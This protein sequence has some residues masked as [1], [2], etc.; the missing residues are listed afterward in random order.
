MTLRNMVAK[1]LNAVL[2]APLP[3]CV[4]HVPMGLKKRDKRDFHI[5]HYKCY[6]HKLSQ[7]STVVHKEIS[8]PSDKEMCTPFSTSSSKILQRLSFSDSENVVFRLRL[9]AAPCEQQFLSSFGKTARRYFVLVQGHD[10]Q[11]PAKLNVYSS[12]NPCRPYSAPVALQM[13][14]HQISLRDRPNLSSVPVVSVRLFVSQADVGT[15]QRPAQLSSQL[16]FLPKLQK[17]EFQRLSKLLLRQTSGVAQR[18]N[19]FPPEL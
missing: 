7:C 1:V 5:F 18:L 13:F 9:R 16:V 14:H 4:Q 2:S 8:P 12:A 3:I 17:H 15:S 6:S 10:C 11:K 19:N